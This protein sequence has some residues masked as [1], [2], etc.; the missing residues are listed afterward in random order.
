[1]RL[2]KVF[3]GGRARKIWVLGLRQADEYDSSFFVVNRQ[4]VRGARRAFDQAA[5]RWGLTSRWTAGECP[6]AQ[7][8]G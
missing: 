3:Y 4:E 5:A 2:A 1:V 8:G 7:E 6:E